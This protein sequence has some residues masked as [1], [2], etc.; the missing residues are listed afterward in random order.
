MAMTHS[1]HA[2]RYSCSLAILAAA[3][4]AGCATEP[5][6]GGLG[7]NAPNPNGCYVFV[8]DQENWRGQRVVLNGPGKWQSLERLRRNDDKDWR[9]N[10]R[11]IEIGSSATVTL[12]TEQNYSGVS[13]Q[14][15]PT[16]DQAR[17]NGSLSAGIE[18][19]ALSC[20]PDKP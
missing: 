12:Y 10:I 8:Y 13:Q 14:F 9:K 16:S 6:L 2:R 3:M 18:S 15:G 5:V 20:R 19:L 1:G 7:G 11:S 17:F 4:L